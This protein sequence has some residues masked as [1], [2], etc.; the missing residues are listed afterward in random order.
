MSIATATRAS[1]TLQLK[2]HYQAKPEQVFAAWSDPNA[3]NQWFG[4]HSHR[5]QTELFEFKP[6]GRWQI[7]MIPTGEVEDP[8]CEGDTTLDSV[9][10]GQFVAIDKP[11]RIVMTFNWIENGAD[12][13]ETLL[14][15]EMYA[16]DGGTDLV[17]TH[18]RIPNEELRKAH[19]SGWQGSLECLENFFAS[20]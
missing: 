2:R 4:P 13:G 12:M 17:L 18:E 10:A 1:E 7:R 16:A 9:C 6:G 19:Q 15:V 5:C 3:L 11:N 20:A 14:S 8:D